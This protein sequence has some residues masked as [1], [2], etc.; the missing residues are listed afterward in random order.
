MAEERIKSFLFLD[1]GERIQALKTEYIKLYQ[2]PKID[3]Q[4]GYIMHDFP[5]RPCDLVRI[6]NKRIKFDSPLKSSSR[7]AT[8]IPGYS[9][10][11]RIVINAKEP[12]VRL[13]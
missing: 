11:Q 3:I 7:Q 6:H 8:Q 9:I 5:I 4:K 1:L 13:D 2:D 10:A 12:G